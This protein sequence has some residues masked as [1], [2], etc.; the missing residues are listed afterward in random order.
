MNTIEWSRDKGAWTGLIQF[1]RR[2]FFALVRPET[3]KG[4]RLFTLSFHYQPKGFDPGPGEQFATERDAKAYAEE[5][6]R[7]RE[8]K[9]LKQ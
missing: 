1:K 6:V 8:E 4:G 3:H 9:A 5:R 7:R 2:I